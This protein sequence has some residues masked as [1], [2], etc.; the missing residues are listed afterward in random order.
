M[1]VYFAKLSEN[2]VMPIQ[3]SAWAAGH[4]LYAAHAATIPAQG[5]FLFFMYCVYNWF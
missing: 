1:K 4:D 5:W 2:A 3:S